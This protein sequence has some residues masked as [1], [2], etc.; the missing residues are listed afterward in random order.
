MIDTI[1]NFTR[2]E[3]AAAVMLRLLFPWLTLLALLGAC[4]DEAS[5]EEDVCSNEHVV[6]D[7]D[8]AAPADANGAY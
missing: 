6:D 7:I 4:S 2:T 1:V 3:H 8:D 5:G